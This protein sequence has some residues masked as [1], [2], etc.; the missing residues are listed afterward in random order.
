MVGRASLWGRVLAS[1]WGRCCSQTEGSGGYGQGEATRSQKAFRW[2]AIVN[3]KVT[4]QPGGETDHYVRF[5]FQSRDLNFRLY[6]RKGQ[7]LPTSITIDLREANRKKAG[8]RDGLEADGV[9]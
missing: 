1:V 6:V 5:K 3:L 8:L 7:P 2:G 9:E 4:A